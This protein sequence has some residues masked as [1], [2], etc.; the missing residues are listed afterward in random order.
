MEGKMKEQN[1]NWDQMN[2][3]SLDVF[4]NQAKK[5]GL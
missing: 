3:E 5:E 4:W 2:L 1:L